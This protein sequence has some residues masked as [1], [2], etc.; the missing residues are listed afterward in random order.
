MGGRMA[1]RQFFG[2]VLALAIG[3]ASIRA[4]DFKPKD[5]L[6]PQLREIAEDHDLDT[7]CDMDGVATK[8]KN[9]LQ[10]T[11]KNNFYIVGDSVTINFNSFIRLQRATDERG[12]PH[13]SDSALPA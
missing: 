13:G 6:P 9:Q 2:G 4:Q 8:K 7:Q 5:A 12:I 1:R 11:A 3:I 10:N